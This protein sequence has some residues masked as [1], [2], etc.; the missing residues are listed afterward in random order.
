MPAAQLAHPEPATLPRPCLASVEPS[1]LPSPRLRFVRKGDRPALRAFLGRLSAS[2]LQARYLTMLSRMEGLLA[3]REIAR[4]V[5]G[6]AARHVVVVAEDRADIRAIGEFV[7]DTDGRAAELALTV[8][9]DFQNH[10]LGRRL[11]C[12]LEA[13]ARRR[14]V[15]AFTGDVR[16]GNTRMQELLRATG[17]PL[18]M[19]SVYGG[20]YF[21][22][23]LA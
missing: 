19:E 3:D 23:Q 20:V 5:D 10:G 2:T 11:Y 18:R 15:A 14:G 6:D 17:R 8:E 21:T 9:D 1:T 12:R 22:L 7:I 13:L 16:H 4:I